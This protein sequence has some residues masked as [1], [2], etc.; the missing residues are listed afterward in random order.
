[1]KRA[2]TPAEINAAFEALRRAR[3][4]ALTFL[5]IE[6]LDRDLARVIERDDGCALAAEWDHYRR[7][8]MPD[9]APAVQVTECQLAFYAGVI[10]ALKHTAAAAILPDQEAI[11]ALER[12]HAEVERFATGAGVLAGMLKH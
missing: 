5:E 8:V 10:S 4:R 12:L 2:A 7:S 1:M 6:A 9:E 11:A 3:R